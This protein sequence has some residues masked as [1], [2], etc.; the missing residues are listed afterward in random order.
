YGEGIFLRSHGQET[1][2]ARSN[3]SAPGGGT[4]DF[5]FL[6]PS[7]LN[8]QG[9]AAFDFL[10]QPAGSPFGVNAGAYRYSHSTQT[11]TPVVVPGVTPAPAGVTF[12]GVSFGPTLNSR[13]DLIFPGIFTTDQGIHIPGEEYIGLGQGLFKPNRDGTIASVL[14]PGDPAPGGG[15]F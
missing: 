7:S 14:S 2:L 10:R 9:D 13:G 5:S 8:D 4:F 12:A 15:T 3:A 11:V 6:G 1:L